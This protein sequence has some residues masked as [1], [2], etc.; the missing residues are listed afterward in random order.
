M[1]DRSR[2]EIEGGEVIN[3]PPFQRPVDIKHA[4]T[5]VRRALMVHIIGVPGPLVN[6]LVS[7]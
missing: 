3:P 2:G 7:H 1:R 5:A 4:P 6:R